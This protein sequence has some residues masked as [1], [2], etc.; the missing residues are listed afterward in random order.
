MSFAPGETIVAEGD[1]AD[2]F[3][4]ITKGEVTISRRGPEGNEVK[5]AR[6]GRGQFFGGVGILPR[7]EGQRP[8]G[9]STTSSCSP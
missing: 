8:Y 3:F 6:L 7:R 5:L 9:R 2:R 4:V 1:P